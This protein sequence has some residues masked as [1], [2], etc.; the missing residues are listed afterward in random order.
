[1]S[2]ETRLKRYQKSAPMQAFNPSIQRWESLS[3]LIDY[4]QI[5]VIV[6]LAITIPSPING[7]TSNFTHPQQR[8]SW[9]SHTLPLGRTI[10]Y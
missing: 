8:A 3:T 6:L 1:M 4:N 9:T 2:A 10:A 5:V 7:N